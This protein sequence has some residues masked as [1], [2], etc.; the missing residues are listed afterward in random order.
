F[1][2][3][4]SKMPKA[5]YA[6]ADKIDFSLAI[7]NTGKMDGDEVVQAYI[8][9]PQSEGMPLKELKAFKKIHI[10]KGTASTVALSIPVS[11]LQKWDIATNNWKLYKGNYTICIGKNASEYLLKKTF[12]VQ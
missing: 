7:N 10:K 1:N 8:E 3:A 9:Y 6:L 12:T 11:D 5:M 4:W 2:Y